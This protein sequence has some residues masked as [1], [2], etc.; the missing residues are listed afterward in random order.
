MNGG[1]LHIEALVSALFGCSISVFIAK[2]AIAKALEDLEK[3][4][5]KIAEITTSLAVISVRIE[6]ITEHELTIQHHTKKLAYLEG[7]H[8]KKRNI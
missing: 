7:A 4:T 2:R 6:K 3:M 5:V 1:E 8:D